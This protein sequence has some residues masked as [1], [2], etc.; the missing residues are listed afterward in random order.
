MRQKN[1]LWEFALKEL[2]PVKGFGKELDV[3]N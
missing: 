1:A 2:A 3:Q